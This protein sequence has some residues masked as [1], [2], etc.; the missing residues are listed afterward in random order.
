MVLPQVAMLMS[1]LLLLPGEKALEITMSWVER[2]MFLGWAGR[3]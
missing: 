2:I 1:L 3:L